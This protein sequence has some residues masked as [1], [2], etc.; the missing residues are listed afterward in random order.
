MKL[1]R[2][3]HTCIHICLN[4]TNDMFMLT[5]LKQKQFSMQNNSAVLWHNIP[6]S[7]VL[8]H[9]IPHEFKHFVN[10]IYKQEYFHPNFK[11][12]RNFISKNVELILTSIDHN[13]EQVEPHQTSH[14]KSRL[15]AEGLLDFCCFRL[16]RRCFH[17]KG[18]RIFCNA[19]PKYH[20]ASVT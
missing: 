18:K 10:K 5:L 15:P 16:F 20:E 2:M 14:C 3:C 4:N 11:D 7:A 6:H 17:W 19:K 1:L 13:A 8:W 12:N 9:N